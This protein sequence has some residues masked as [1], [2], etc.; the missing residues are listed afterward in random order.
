MPVKTLPPQEYLRQCFAYD[1]ETGVLTWRE[2]PID[3]FSTTR[4]RGWWNAKYAG[5]RAGRPHASG[6]RLIN[7]AGKMYAE[8][9]VIW[10]WMTGED[11]GDTVDHKDTVNNN[12]RWLNLRIATPTQQNW[13]KPKTRRR[14]V[15]PRRGRFRSGI[16]IN[17]KLKWLGTFD[18]EDEAAAAYEREARRLHGE[19]FRE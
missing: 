1:P 18:T 6:Y 17:G 19:F 7:L 16:A 15:Y 14:G 3:H 10:K 12:N 4:I 11:P 2:R 8:H 5:T 9:R 13:N